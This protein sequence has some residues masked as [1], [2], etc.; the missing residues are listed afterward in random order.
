MQSKC[1]GACTAWGLGL[2]L[3]SEHTKAAERRMLDGSGRLP[4]TGSPLDVTGWETRGSPAP[5]P[6][7]AET[8]CASSAWQCSE[9]P[10]SPPRASAN[11]P[12]WQGVKVP[13]LG[14]KHLVFHASQSKANG[15]HSEGEDEESC[16]PEHSGPGVKPARR[17]RKATSALGAPEE[18]FTPPLQP[19]PGSGTVDQTEP[20][21]V[22]VSE[23]LEQK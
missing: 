21:K 23:V 14:V 9:S 17:G 13:F 20:K 15:Q 3:W 5:Q 11:S 22:S 4:S 7:G 2:S 1:E 8:P 19:Q 16:D 6:S 12:A 18:N 10:C